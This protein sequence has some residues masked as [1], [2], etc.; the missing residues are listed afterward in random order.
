MIEILRK[1]DEKSSLS[2]FL[3]LPPELRS[4]IYKYAIADIIAKTQDSRVR[5]PSPGLCRINSETRR[6]SLPL[7]LRET[8]QTIIV[9]WVPAGPESDHSQKPVLCDEY[10]T[11]F[12]DA[13]EFGWLQ[14]MRLFHFRIMKLELPTGVDGQTKADHNA[15]Y[16]VKFAKMMENV[17]TWC[18]VKDKKGP[19][20]AAEDQFLSKIKAEMSAIQLSGNV[21]MNSKDFE[22]MIGIFLRTVDQHYAE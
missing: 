8:A 14:H 17:E 12:K 20:P 16:Y 7:F 9:S 3:E 21:T 15:R 11:Y 2:P 10:R 18:E 1:A 5:P 6:E 13:R 4:E 22:S 19:L